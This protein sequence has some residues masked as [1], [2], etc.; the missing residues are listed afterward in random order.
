MLRSQRMKKIDVLIMKKLADVVSKEIVRFGD[1]Q[2][3]EI[4]G[5]K[6]KNYML[7]KTSID[8]DMA[9]YQE[10]DKRINFLTTAFES[11]LES[12]NMKEI[13]E[14]I[15]TEIVKQEDIEKHIKN[16]ESDLNNYYNILEKLKSE[17]T[18][19]AIKVKRIDYFSNYNLDWKKLSE[20][21]YFSIG[22]GSIPS[23][24]YDGFN[25]AMET[26][27]SVLNYIDTIRDDILVFF[28]V[29]KSSKEK[30]DQ[31]LKNVFFKDYGIP[32]SEEEINK[33]KLIH[34]A[35]QLSA[36]YDE[37]LWQEKQYRNMVL[38]Y[39]MLLKKLKNSIQY[40][41][42]ME[43]LKGEMVSTNKVCLFSGWVPANQIKLLKINIEEVTSKQCVFLE[44]DALEAL[45]KEGL[46]PPTKFSNPFFLKPFEGLVS[47]FGLPNYREIDPTPIAALT[48][49]IMY[50]AMF[51][52]VGHG[53]V[54]AL[55]GILILLVKKLKSFR[56]F[57]AIFLGIG[58]SSALFG[59][60]YGAIFGY[61]NVFK[62]LWIRPMEHI[63]DILVVAV[64]F[65]AGMIM[66]GIIISIINSLLEKN[67]GRLFFSPNGIAGLAFY[68]SLLY[69]GYSVMSNKPFIPYVW[70]IP[71]VC[72]FMIAFEKILERKLFHHEEGAH[73]EKPSIA[74]GF[75]EVFESSMSFLSNTISFI[76]V[77]AFA[78]NHGALMSV[79]FVLAGM[80]TN[81]IVQWIAL[82]I[83]NLFVIG[84]EGFIVAIQVLRLEYYE[85]FVKFFRAN[86]KAFEGLGIYKS[87]S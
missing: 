62:P 21:K 34:Y 36:S 68:G 10:L 15:D 45:R 61:E 60:F 23:T 53:I 86:G 59:L 87:S 70:I 28:I 76:R 35:F 49:L 7:Y 82:L 77:G 73:D 1:F 64:L 63:M 85:F 30:V 54:I 13:E 6:A 40:Y 12:L 75:V 47:T 50:G 83:G 84:F 56:D 32:N 55:L 71:A 24:S 79:V 67:Y 66:L 51:G 33:S 44:Q 38:K 4:L 58:L 46:T 57:G 18:D 42:S 72:V 14:I 19:I 29:S 20:V 16:I 5:E 80:S 25:S 9:R 74:L 27:P 41:I 65:G 3:I 48:Y 43:R 17:Q 81:P 31:I 78:L 2:T 22:F 52:D 11:A 37:E 69:V 26:L 8:G 39:T